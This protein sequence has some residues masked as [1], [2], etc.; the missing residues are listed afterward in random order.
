MNTAGLQTRLAR[1]T[2]NARSGIVLATVAATFAVSQPAV[3]AVPSPTSQLAHLRADVRAAVSAQRHHKRLSHKAYEQIRELALKLEA[4]LKKGPSPCRTSLSAAQRLAG[5]RGRARRLKADLRRAQTGLLKCP[6]V[7][8][9]SPAA[10]TDPTDNPPVAVLQA[11][12]SETK[13][14]TVDATDFAGTQTDESLMTS[15]PAPGDPAECTGSTCVVQL[16]YTAGNDTTD[17]TASN[18]LPEPE[19]PPGC[20]YSDTFVMPAIAPTDAA[21]LKLEYN[22]GG[23]L[24]SAEVLFQYGFGVGF[25]PDFSNAGSGAILMY[26][27]IALNGSSPE[28]AK[29]VNPATL[30]EGKAVNVDISDSGSAVESGYYGDG[31]NLWEGGKLS[32]ELSYSNTTHLTFELRGSR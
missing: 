12:T 21:Q 4:L 23:K 2:R 22:D 20:S 18:N 28:I 5:E 1:L 32:G 10:P 16:E 26:T 7:L 25:A 30:S 15:N 9:P 13:T 14:R 29:P 19:E 3:A 31:A 24:T 11:F 8:I 6:A 17:I 27:C